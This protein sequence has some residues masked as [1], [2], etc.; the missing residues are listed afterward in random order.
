MQIFRSLITLLILLVVS[1]C[2]TDNV[3]ADGIQHEKSDTDQWNLAERYL[4]FEEYDNAAELY[5]YLLDKDPGNHHLSYK[6]AYAKLKSGDTDM[7]SGAIDYFKYASEN[8][9][10]FTRNRLQCTRSPMNVYHYLGRAYELTGN[11]NEAQKYFEKFDEKAGYFDKKS[12]EISPRQLFQNAELSL[13]Y[14]NYRSALNY[15]KKLLEYYPD[16]H[17]FNFKTGYIY[18]ISEELQNIEVAREYLQFATENTTK[19][20][21]NKFRTKKA[22]HYSLYYYGVTYMLE[23]DYEKAL[24]IFTDYKENI[25]IKDSRSLYADL[26]NR[27]IKTSQAG[28]YFIR[29][30]RMKTPRIQVEGLDRELI[31][32]Q[33]FCS[34]AKRLIFTYGSSNVF[35]RDLNFY[36]NYDASAFDS[37][38]IAELGED[39]IF[40]SPINITKDLDIRHPHLPVSATADCKELYIVVDEG[41]QGDS[42]PAYLASRDGVEHCQQ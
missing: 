2:F 8:T 12:I 38:Y 36:H 1:Q 16:N 5:K 39:G 17:H 14:E 27:D 22:P 13:A 34:D 35:P 19:R 33:I 6:L 29:E 4:F 21:R 18:L 7:L 15:Y 26:V 41:D 32:C 9:G 24:K 31:R 42:Y 28:G 25:G 20:F 10:R 3:F 40:H 30:E 11:E 37:I 23:K